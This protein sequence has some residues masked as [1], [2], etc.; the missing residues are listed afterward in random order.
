GRRRP[1]RRLRAGDA[2]Q[3]NTKRQRNRCKRG[4]AT[5]EAPRPRGRKF[6]CAYA[7]SVAP[8]TAASRLSLKRRWGATPSRHASLAEAKCS[9]T[10]TSVIIG[11]KRTGRSRGQVPLQLR[12]WLPLAVVAPCSAARASMNSRSLQRLR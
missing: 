8:H 1:S 5:K 4:T 3:A 12:R 2:R 11:V 6:G 9:E 7:E 10:V